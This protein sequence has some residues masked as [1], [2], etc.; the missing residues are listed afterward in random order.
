MSNRIA[1]IIKSRRK[2]LA[3]QSPRQWHPIHNLE[4]DG[5]ARWGMAGLPRAGRLALTKSTKTPPYCGANPFWLIMS[6]SALA[7]STE[8][9]TVDE[10]KRIL[11]KLPE[12]TRS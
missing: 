7:D 6:F 10:E 5:H 2:T 4:V 1:F 8:P 3:G 11:G 9:E 12:P